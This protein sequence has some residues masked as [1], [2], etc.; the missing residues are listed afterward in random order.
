MADEFVSG[1]GLDLM[2][3]APGGMTAGP[4]ASLSALVSDSG[5]L[6]HT[7]VSMERHEHATNRM[8]F[9]RW[10]WWEMRMVGETRNFVYYSIVPPLQYTIVVHIGS[11]SDFS[12]VAGAHV[13]F[14]GFSDSSQCLAPAW[15][16]RRSDVEAVC[17]MVTG[18]AIIL[19]SLSALAGYFPAN[20]VV[21]GSARA[22]KVTLTVFAAALL[23][24]MSSSGAPESKKRR[25]ARTLK[26][27]AR[28]LEESLGTVL[29]DEEKAQVDFVVAELSGPKRHLCRTVASLL[30]KG[31]LEALLRSKEEAEAQFGDD[32]VKLRNMKMQDIMDLIFALEPG[33]ADRDAELRSVGRATLLKWAMFALNAKE[34]HD[35]PQEPPTLRMKRAFFEFCKVRY[36]QVGSRMKVLRDCG[37]ISGTS[38]AGHF[39]HDKTT[40]K[41]LCLTELDDDGNPLVLSVDLSGA[42]D[43][44]ITQ[45]YQTDSMLTSAQYGC[46]FNLSSRLKRD[47]LW[48]A[49]VWRILRGGT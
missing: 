47:S 16:R 13:A 12:G 29:E 15:V 17:T 22:A 20:I 21:R 31:T 19:G 14:R 9:W 41:I 25:T 28:L 43:W 44:T 38:V 18:R 8:C 39:K 46:F 6:L 23:E 27:E 3:F 1:V 32:E 30:R 45:K 40:S 37:K 26:K 2:C 48:G 7:F 4:I 36:L 33:L 34:A 42:S 49:M 24:I 5:C 11:G 10:S 35:M